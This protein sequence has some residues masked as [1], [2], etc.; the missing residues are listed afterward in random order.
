MSE[1]TQIKLRVDVQNSPEQP[2]SL[3]H[4]QQN[5]N[6]RT[7]FNWQGAGSNPIKMLQLIRM[8]NCVWYKTGFACHKTIREMLMTSNTRSIIFLC[9]EYIRIRQQR[10]ERTAFVSHTIRSIW[11]SF[12]HDSDF[13]IPLSFSFTVA[14][15]TALNLF[16]DILTLGAVTRGEKQTKRTITLNQ[17]CKNNHAYWWTR[18]R[19]LDFCA[20]WIITQYYH[21]YYNHN[22]SFL[23]STGISD[24]NIT[25]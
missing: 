10:E 13:C 4:F 19:S 14:L 17:Q 24:T 22:I 8:T 1:T 6:R 21:L 16:C 2:S 11:V 15:L 20:A 23:N 12:N 3:H 7:R 9:Y 18:A 5:W 25:Y